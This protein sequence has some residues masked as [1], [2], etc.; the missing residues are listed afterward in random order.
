M[1]RGVRARSPRWVTWLPALVVGVLLIS[2]QGCAPGTPDEGSWRDDARRA[3]SDVSSSLETARLALEEDTNG[4][5]FDTYVQTVAVDAEELAGS[6]SEKFASIQPPE[7]ERQRY[8]VVTRQL[9]D[10]ADLL[11]EVRIAVVAGHPA[12]YSE[13][14]EKLEEAATGLDKLDQDLRHPPVGTGRP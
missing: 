2:V 6:S 10:A 7:A 14:I 1:L 9:G 13:L 3:I 4:H 8:D 12:S 5:L 11:G